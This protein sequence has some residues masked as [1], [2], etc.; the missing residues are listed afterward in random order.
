[1]CAASVREQA[2]PG[3]RMCAPEMVS[4]EV[5]AWR[6]SETE[7]TASGWMS[8]CTTKHGSSVALA[9]APAA[10][11]SL[12]SAPPNTALASVVPPCA[13]QAQH[14]LDHSDL[15]YF[16]QHTRSHPLGDRATHFPL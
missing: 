13:A 5:K 3:A 8:R 1:M 10:L 15:Y 9:G 11:T 4:G 2:G 6:A 12:R 7:R 16:S 14:N